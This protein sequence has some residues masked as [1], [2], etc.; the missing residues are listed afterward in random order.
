[1]SLGIISLVLST[2]SPRATHF[3]YPSFHGIIIQ[4]KE[5]VVEDED[6]NDNKIEGFRIQGIICL[7]D[8]FE[9]ILDQEL[10]D[11]DFHLSFID[12][13]GVTPTRKAVDS[14]LS[15]FSNVCRP[16]L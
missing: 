11:S 10:K 3:N 13:Y 1:M 9:E 5:L 16:I 2:R 12:Q 14:S 6:Q 15:R 4:R 8:V 7:K